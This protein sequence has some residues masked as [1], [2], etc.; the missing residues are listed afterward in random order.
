MNLWNSATVVEDTE[1]KMVYSNHYKN[2]L[3]QKSRN[4]NRKGDDR[5]N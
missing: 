1:L 2:L 3:M 4:T 5:Y